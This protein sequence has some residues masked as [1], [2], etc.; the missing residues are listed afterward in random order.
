MDLA[1]LR[2]SLRLRY[3]N[4]GNSICIPREDR[5]FVACLAVS[6][7][8]TRILLRTS[9]DRNKQKNDYELVNNRADIKPPRS[10]RQFC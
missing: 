8:T 6:L 10:L 3:F 7:L 5:G 4:L 9:E 1:M 2:Q